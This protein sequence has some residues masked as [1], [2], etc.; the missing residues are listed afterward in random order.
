MELSPWAKTPGSS[1]RNGELSTKT[2]RPINRV[3]ARRRRRPTK[4]EATR[5]APVYLMPVARPRSAPGRR[6][7]HPALPLR[8]REI[9]A[10]GAEVREIEGMAVGAWARRGT[11]SR[12]RAQNRG[13]GTSIGAKWLSRALRRAQ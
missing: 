11:A 6:Y 9:E 8:G 7:P 3:R 10:L 13:R 12:V 4:I 2:A 1:T 5:N